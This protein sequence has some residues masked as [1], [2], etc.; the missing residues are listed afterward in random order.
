VAGEVLDKEDCAGKG[1][2]GRGKT[3]NYAERAILERYKHN[4]TEGD[5]KF[6]KRGHVFIKNQNF[7]VQ[8]PAV[9]ERTK[10]QQRKEKGSRKSIEQRVEQGEINAGETLTQRKTQKR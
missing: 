1:T 9:S 10:I 7:E 8:K 3:K 2:T 6:R 5:E 4:Q